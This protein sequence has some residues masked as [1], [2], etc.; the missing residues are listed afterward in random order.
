[1]GFITGSIN[2]GLKDPA[3]DGYELCRALNAIGDETLMEE[4]RFWDLRAVWMFFIAGT[5]NS[6]V[7]F[8]STKTSL[9]TAIASI[10]VA[11]KYLV[12]LACTQFSAKVWSLA[13]EERSSLGKA[14][15]TEMS[16]FD[17]AVK[18]V[19]SVS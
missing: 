10:F 2:S 4:S 7:L 8:G 13:V 9:P 11:G 15:T 1:M 16:E 3:D 19:E 6:V 5:R 14:T 17:S 18:T 12:M